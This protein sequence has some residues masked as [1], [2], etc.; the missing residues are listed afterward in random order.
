MSA[1]ER[2]GLSEAPFCRVPPHRKEQ[3]GQEGAREVRD[4]SRLGVADIN[5]LKL[6]TLCVLQLLEG[7]QLPG[8]PPKDLC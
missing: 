1:R 8:V 7:R 5:G 3:R 4:C 2:L 6:L